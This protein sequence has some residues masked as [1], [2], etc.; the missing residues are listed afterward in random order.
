MVTKTVLAGILFP[1]AIYVCLAGI[2]LFILACSL[3]VCV[4]AFRQFVHKSYRK[5]ILLYWPEQTFDFLGLPPEVRVEVYRYTLPKDNIYC[6]AARKYRFYSRQDEFIKDEV[7]RPL[8]SLL[9]V[10]R[11]VHEE[12]C[13]LIYGTGIFCIT[14]YSIRD[15]LYTL[16]LLEKYATPTTFHS[17]TIF[18]MMRQI[19][20]RVNDV[21]IGMT[22]RPSIRILSR[23]LHMT[24]IWHGRGKAL[25]RDGTTAMRLIKSDARLRSRRVPW[26]EAE[27]LMYLLE[28]I[29]K[30]GALNRRALI[31]MLPWYQ[32][33]QSCQDRRK[34]SLSPV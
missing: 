6:M 13:P 11:L 14:I 5:L 7:A 15:L 26:F 20:L 31:K 28:C 32:R 3:Y 10:C 24:P 21:I 29:F 17:T 9:R 23:A 34:A 4:T 2:F 22:L 19:V 8:P 12:L 1:I 25:L 30:D 16:D 33:H 18:S 27:D